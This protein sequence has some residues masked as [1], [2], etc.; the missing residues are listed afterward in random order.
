MKKIMNEKG[1]SLMEVV[2]SLAIL[3]IMILTFANLFLFTNKTAVSNDSK[4]VAIHLA[5]AEL[6]RLKVNSDESKDIISQLKADSNG[7]YT[8]ER[9]IN[10]QKY[11]VNFKRTQSI[12]EKNMRLL[13]IVVEVSLL[14]SKPVISS[15]VEGYVNDEN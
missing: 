11:K 14:N 9:I 5:K 4:I 15:K 12:D 3:S 13:N 1:I 6:E 10:N 8:R 2:V 7:V